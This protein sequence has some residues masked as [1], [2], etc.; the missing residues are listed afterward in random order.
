M[1]SCLCCTVLHP[2][3]T[4]ELLVGVQVG[5]G[6]VEMREEVKAKVVHALP[7][8]FLRKMR[9][10]QEVWRRRPIVFNPPQPAIQAP[11]AQLDSNKQFNQ[12]KGVGA[13]PQSTWIMHSLV[14]VQQVWRAIHT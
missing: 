7:P 8:C 11:T 12:G 2:F 1:G 10:A 4:V 14:G 9:G 3:S 5:G 6:G 13:G